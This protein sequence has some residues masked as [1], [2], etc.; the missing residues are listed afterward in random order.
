[1]TYVPRASSL[2]CALAMYLQDDPTGFSAGQIEGLVR[3]LPASDEAEER[4]RAKVDEWL[5]DTPRYKL[6]MRVGQAWMYGLGSVY[7]AGLGA[8]VGTA[9][10]GLM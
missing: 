8:L 4:R 3:T 5:M 7:A 2:D 6:G 1:M 10:R 9:I